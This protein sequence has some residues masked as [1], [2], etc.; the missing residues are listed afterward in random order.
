MLDKRPIL[1]IEI[2]RPKVADTLLCE[3]NPSICTA[4]ASNTNIQLCGNQTSGKT[5]MM[6]L[7]KY[8]VKSVLA[9]SSLEGLVRSSITYARNMHSQAENA[10]TESRIASN[11]MIRTLNKIQRKQEVP[12]TIAAS[13]VLGHKSFDSTHAFGHINCQ[14]AITLLKQL[15]SA[16]TVSDTDSDSDSDSETNSAEDDNDDKHENEDFGIRVEQIRS[17]ISFRLDNAGKISFYN[18]AQCFAYRGSELPTMS[19]YEYES[20]VEI[21]KMDQEQIE[22]NGA[23]RPR[24]KTFPF[25]NNFKVLYTILTI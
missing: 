21:K 9:L 2:K 5:I 25:P 24:S 6:Y 20:I 13:A 8:M 10:G 11:S 16:D 1:A 23:G 15:N 17:G 7:S 4:V 18:R 19:Y 3:H 14:D 22:N 12:G